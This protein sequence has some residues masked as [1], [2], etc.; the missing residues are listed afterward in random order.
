MFGI[1]STPYVA[2]EPK[3]RISS[4]F[5]FVIIIFS[6]TFGVA[7][8][9]DRIVISG[10]DLTVN[11]DDYTYASL[12]VSTSTM[13]TV[14]QM[15]TINPPTP[16]NI[17]NPCQPYSNINPLEYFLAINGWTSDTLYF[18]V[19][20]SN[21]NL[22]YWEMGTAN[23]YYVYT[24]GSGF[25]YENT[26]KFLLI[27]PTHRENVSS[28]TPYNLHVRAY[29]APNDVGK[30]IRYTVYSR[31]GGSSLVLGNVDQFEIKATTTGIFDYGQ[32]ASRNYNN[33]SYT[34]RVILHKKLL[35][36]LPGIPVISTTTNW[37]VGAE[38]AF[39]SSTLQLWESLD[40]VT[41][42]IDVSECSLSLSGVNLIACLKYMIVPSGE[43]LNQDIEAVR[44]I[45]P[46]GYAFRMY[47]IW[48]ASS[49]TQLPSLSIVEPV[50][51]QNFDLTP[52]YMIMGTSSLLAQA[53]SEIT[54]NG[55]T[56]GSGESLR[57]ITETYWNM[58]WYILLGFA[59][60]NDLLK[61]TRSRHIS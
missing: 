24:L 21:S 42:N 55:N 29:I 35:G 20:L 51:G 49:T 30:Y 11:H 12:C 46:W 45:A 28:T 40:E 7:Y 17:M 48:S 32:V 5:L 44:N 38:S 59:I 50:T 37:Y 19:R 43:Q 8:A 22:N 15:Q 26:S 14:A 16:P 33:G 34:S 6:A 9:E 54:V 52:W 53:R 4:V 31:D 10:D 18:V 61:L 36:L 1:K 2:G 47:D 25:S 57:E 13:P 60:V 39:G 58:I 3:K 27:E 41:Q 56:Y 23:E